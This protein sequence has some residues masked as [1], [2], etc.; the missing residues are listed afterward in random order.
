MHKK[1]FCFS[2]TSKY[3]HHS[4]E[5]GH[6]GSAIQIAQQWSFSVQHALQQQW[7]QPVWY[8][9]IVLWETTFRTQKHWSNNADTAPYHEPFNEL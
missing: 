5:R 9:L 7:Y 3:T 4:A 6:I 2:I 8:G 1:V